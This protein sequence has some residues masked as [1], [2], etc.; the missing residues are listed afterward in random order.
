VARLPEPA[1]ADSFRAAGFAYP[2]G[3]AAAGIGVSGIAP[4]AACRRVR[5]IEIAMRYARGMVFHA[6]IAAVPTL[7]WPNIAD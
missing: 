2:R 5:N 1:A 6:S 4:R 7:L 3:A